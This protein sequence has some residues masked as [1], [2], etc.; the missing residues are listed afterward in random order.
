MQIAFNALIQYLKNPTCETLKISVNDKL[1]IL[2]KLLFIALIISFT[3]GILIHFLEHFGLF[4]MDS[5]AITK[6]L[7]EKPKIIV[8]LMAVFVAPILE[9][10][11][12]RAPIVLFCHNKQFKYLFYGF[13][14]VFGFIHIANYE[15]S[16]TILLLSPLLI[17][18]QIA[19][20]LI[21]GYTR[22]KLGLLYAILL[23]M[24]FNGLL[25]SPSLIVMDL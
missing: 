19:L 2:T 9:E 17:S 5:H 16:S 12:F 6:L 21:L 7:N 1:K 24:V 13:A 18:P 15:I 10:L 22:V 23:H 11:F 25:I 3:L 14:I 4:K 20:G 8:F